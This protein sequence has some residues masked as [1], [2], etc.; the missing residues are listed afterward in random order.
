MKN[1]NLLKIVFDIYPGKILDTL[2]NRKNIS[3]SM[4]LKRPYFYLTYNFFSILN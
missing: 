4:F 1:E 2:D 3:H